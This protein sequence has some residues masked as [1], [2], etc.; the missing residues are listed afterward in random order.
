MT[1]LEI[2]MAKCGELRD[3]LSKTEAAAILEGRIVSKCNAHIEK[4]EAMLREMIDMVP[5]EYAYRKNSADRAQ[6]VLDWAEPTQSR[7]I[8]RL[9]LA[10]RD[11]TPD[12]VSIDPDSFTIDKE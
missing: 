5:Q 3:R 1:E 10:L 4:L 7:P 9:A 2:Y 6:A 11:L 12:D 8:K